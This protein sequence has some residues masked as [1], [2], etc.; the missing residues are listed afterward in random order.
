M[1]GYGA[2]FVEVVTATAIDIPAQEILQDVIA[3]FDGTTILVSHDRYLIDALATQ[4]WS[5]DKEEEILEVFKGN[6][7]EFRAQQDES[8]AAAPSGSDGSFAAVPSPAA[9]PGRC[10]RVALAAFTSDFETRSASLRS[11]FRRQTPAPIT[12]ASTM[13]NN[14]YME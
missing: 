2:E 4:V 5:I 7:S 8:E 3:N 13:A 10:E 9:V 12:P 14:L 1:P 11:S 6:Y